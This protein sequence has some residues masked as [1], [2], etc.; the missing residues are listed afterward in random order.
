MLLLGLLLAGCGGGGGTGAQSQVTGTVIDSAQNDAPVSG[1]TVNM[2]GATATTG[3]DGSFTIRNAPLG[4]GVATVTAPGQAPQKIGFL[5]KIAPG[6]D[7]AVTLTLNIG[8]IGGRVLYK[9]QPLAGVSVLE[10]TT[11]TPTATDSDGTFLLED[12]PMTAAGS[13]D[14]VIFVKGTAS[15]TQTVNVVAGLND[16][17]DV[18]ITDSTDGSTP[19]GIPP[20]TIKGTVKLSDQPSSATAG[21]GTTLILLRNGVQAD[22]TTADANG[23]YSFYAPVANNYS[24]QAIRSAYQTQTSSVFNVVDSRKQVE[25]DLTLQPNP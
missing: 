3:S 11:G 10:E 5:P 22:T 24:V 8:Q 6:S 7:N 19:P 23:N 4:T 2:G 14:T 9:G 13:P 12:I 15:A 21:A 1:A 16:L 25:V 20:P 17:G 18:T